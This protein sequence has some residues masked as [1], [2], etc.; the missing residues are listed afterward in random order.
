MVCGLDSGA[1]GPDSS[2]GWRHHC[3]VFLGSTLYS[4]SS[5]LHLGA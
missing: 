3:V 5:S 4:H 1:K 2:P